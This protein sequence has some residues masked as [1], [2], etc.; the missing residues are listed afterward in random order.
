MSQTGKLVEAMRSGA[1][2]L[3]L[4]AD[5]AGRRGWPAAKVEA[6]EHAQVLD[7]AADQLQ[8]RR[9]RGT[10]AEVQG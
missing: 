4:S 10:T 8:A 5:M 9:T 6:L 1:D 2:S 7:G 3:R